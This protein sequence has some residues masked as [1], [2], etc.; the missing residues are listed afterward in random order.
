MRLGISPIGWTN[1]SILDLGDDIPFERFAGE[2]AE[3][4][5]T[6]VELG[7]KF[8][9]DPLACRAALAAVG[10]VP[11]TGWYSGELARRSAAA[12]WEA[13]QPFARHLRALG[14]TLLVYGE[15]GHGPDRGSAARLA[16]AIPFELDEAYALRVDAFA[17]DLASAGLTLVY[18]PHM[19]QAV[20][21]DARIDRLMEM[22]GAAVRLL[23]DTGHIAMSGGDWLAIAR[24]WWHRIGHVH[25]KDVDSAVLRSLDPA[26]HSFDDGVRM[27]LFTVPGSGSIDFAPLA[28]LIAEHGYEGWCIVEAERDPATP[29]P[30]ELA[31]RSFGYLANIFAEAGVAFD[32]PVA[33]AAR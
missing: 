17:T 26:V 1:Q 22:T 16:D 14:S 29:P 19:M 6:G 25:L 21:T 11:V 12:E 28:R 23:L 20:D 10:L 18:H 27:G 31:S 5:F 8:P 30:G 32:R 9:E 3:A 7:R 24:R 15:C 33:E 2:A 4:G 13:V